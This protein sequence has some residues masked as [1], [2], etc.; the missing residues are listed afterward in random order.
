MVTFDDDPS[1][2]QIVLVGALAIAFI[3]LGIVVVFNTS[4]YADNVDSTGTVSSVNQAEQVRHAGG[5]SVAGLA[6]RVN[7]GNHSAEESGVGTAV[8]D[9]T[10]NL[11]VVWQS[12]SAQ[13]R[14]T[15]INV[16]LDE[17]NSEYGVRVF[18]PRNNDFRARDGG[19]QANWTITPTSSTYSDIGEFNLTL[20][21]DSL[22]TSQSGAFHLAALGGDG[23]GDES[24]RVVWF[25]ND[26]SNIDVYV[27]SGSAGSAPTGWEDQTGSLACD[28]VSAGPTVEVD[29]LNGSIEDTSCSF[30]FADD[31]AFVP[32][33]DGYE[34]QF[35]NGGNVTGQY[36]VYLS[37]TAFDSNAFG[38]RVGN[39][40]DAPYYSYILWETTAIVEYGS[41]GASYTR[42]ATVPVYNST[43]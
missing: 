5:Q 9:R 20:E 41:P 31:M 24:W 1:R 28:D 15:V 27:A 22:D 12:L 8:E 11:S 3:I 34:L 25:V 42:T 32:S 40:G 33:Q 18:Q 30:E 10:D 19:N 7:Q 35:R 43:R 39:P 29:M 4:L 13:S 26:S 17:S 38:T 14:P 37:E 36:H 2:A 16:S 21:R 23:S 6:Y